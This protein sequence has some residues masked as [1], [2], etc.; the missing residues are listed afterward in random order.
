MSEPITI[1][2]NT[3]IKNSVRT[4]V[5]E[6]L[7]KEMVIQEY[8]DHH[9]DIILEDRKVY[10]NVKVKIEQHKYDLCFEYSDPMHFDNREITIDGEKYDDGEITSIHGTAKLLQLKSCIGAG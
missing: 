2:L 7:V 8:Y 10:K 1:K 6:G 4:L 3:K 9:G 5:F